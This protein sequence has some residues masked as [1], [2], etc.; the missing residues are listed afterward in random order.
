M[1]SYLNSHRV[2]EETIEIEMIFIAKENRNNGEGTKLYLEWEKSLPKE[3]KCVKLFAADTGSGNSY[4]FWE[5]LG[6]EFKYTGD[7]LEDITSAVGYEGTYTMIK[8]VNGHPT[9]K[10]IWVEPEEENEDYANNK[11]FKP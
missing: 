11:K 1:K 7:S 9:P 2:N 5:R 6:Y 8:G 4:P 10:S 3:I